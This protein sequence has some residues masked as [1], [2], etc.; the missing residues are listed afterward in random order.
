MTKTAKDSKKQSQDQHI[1]L[2]VQNT[3]L[4]AQEAHYHA[5]CRRDY[6]REDDRHQG[7]IKDTKTIEELASNKTTNL[8]SIHR[9][10]CYGQNRLEI[11]R[12]PCYG[13]SMKLEHSTRLLS[14]RCQQNV[15]KHLIRVE[16][17]QCH[18]AE[19]H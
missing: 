3:D 13:R 7:I 17:S 6:S 1:L 8:F 15:S 12:L 16:Q 2:K 10:L 19:M 11:K 18:H 9:S 5:T 4:A 14:D